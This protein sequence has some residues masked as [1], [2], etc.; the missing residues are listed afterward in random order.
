M[1]C[2][3]CRN[4]AVANDDEICVQCKSADGPDFED[5]YETK[6]QKEHGRQEFDS[7]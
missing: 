4:N 5:E 6:Q 3:T 2:K 7:I 1:W